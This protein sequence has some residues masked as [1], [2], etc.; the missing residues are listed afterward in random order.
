MPV[1]K[2]VWNAVLQVNG[3][4]KLW[5]QI[6][7]E[8][9]KVARCTVGKRRQLCCFLRFRNVFFTDWQMIQPVG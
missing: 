7:R 3:D 2:Q 1:V 6:S 8:G 5:K 4:D 9:D